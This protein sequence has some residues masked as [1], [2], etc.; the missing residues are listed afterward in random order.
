MW[1]EGR[2]GTPGSVT[3]CIVSV[4]YTCVCELV[5]VCK[6]Y[7]RVVCICVCACVCAGV[8]LLVCAHQCIPTCVLLCADVR[9]FEGGSAPV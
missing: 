6:G 1:G 4:G 5:R 7:A 9:P 8:Y 3:V 2:R